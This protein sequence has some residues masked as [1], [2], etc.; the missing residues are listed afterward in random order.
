MIYRE[1]GGEW[2]ETERERER[3]SGENLER[4]KER[5]LVIYREN[6]KVKETKKKKVDRQSNK[7]T[8]DKIIDTKHHCSHTDNS[9]TGFWMGREI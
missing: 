4:G 3:E 6:E 9:D 7:V 1:S 2:S 8:M 5:E